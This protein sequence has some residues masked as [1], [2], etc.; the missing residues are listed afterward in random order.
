MDKKYKCFCCMKAF[1]LVELIIVIAIIGILVALLMPGIG[2]AWS[3]AQMMQ[4]QTNLSTLYKAQ[5]NWNADRESIDSTSSAWS[6]LLGSYLEKRVEVLRC[7]SAISLSIAIGGEILPGHEGGDIGSDNNDGYSM[8]SAYVNPEDCDLQLQDV[9]IGVTDEMNNTLYEIPLTPSPFWSWFQSW[10]LPDGRTHIG[11]NL[12]NYFPKDSLGRY[13][14]EDFLFIVTYSGSNLSKV[15]IGDC[16]GSANKYWTDFRL[17]HKP[18]WDGERF[19][20]NFAQGHIGEVIDVKEEIAKQG[21]II[22]TGPRRRIPYSSWTIMASSKTILGDTSYGLNRGSYQAI[23]KQNITIGRNVPKPDPKLIFL[24][25]YPKSIADMTDIPDNLGEK[26]F[27]DQIFIRPTPPIN[28]RTPPGLSGRT[29]EECQALRH[30]GKSNV[31]FCD[32]HIESL[33]KEELD[34]FINK[35]IWNYQGK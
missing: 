10:T 14:D 24:L 6:A 13:T 7:P 16:D 2:N 33:N 34:P 17:N 18:I 8:D 9:T 28:W 29:W 25:D 27:F 1:T 35:D 3:V 21:N 23:D 4:C 5:I 12:D 26:G 22:G 19:K 11:A 31:L 30:F 32:G 20:L 15:E